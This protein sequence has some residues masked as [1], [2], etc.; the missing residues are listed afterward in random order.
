MFK[1]ADEDADS[2][3]KGLEEVS[4]PLES[5]SAPDSIDTETKPKN[6]V[7]DMNTGEIREVNW[8]RPR[9]LMTGHTVVKR[10]RSSRMRLFSHEKP[11]LRNN[12]Y[13]QN[14]R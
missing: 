1:G 14:Y 4:S 8:V 6:I 10:W 3:P 9:Q 7:R 13:F 11:A 2:K 12:L 5:M